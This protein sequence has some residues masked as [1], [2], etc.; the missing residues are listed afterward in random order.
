LKILNLK[1]YVTKIPPG[2]SRPANQNVTGETGFSNNID[3]L[4][5]IIF[6]ATAEVINHR[7]GI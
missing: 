4:Y 2:A 5:K 1:I 3:A 7:T 6:K